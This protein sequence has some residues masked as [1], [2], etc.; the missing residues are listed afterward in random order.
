MT[1]IRVDNV[2]ICEIFWHNFDIFIAKESVSYAYMEKTLRL[3][4]GYI[5]TKRKEKKLPKPEIIE[6]I[7]QF[8]QI[9][10]YFMFYISSDR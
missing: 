3:Y 6:I 1:N 4:D 10:Y 8:F 5:Y 7:C 2:P 9:P